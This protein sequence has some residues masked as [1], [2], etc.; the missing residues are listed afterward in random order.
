MMS[1]A[2]KTWRVTISDKSTRKPLMGWETSKKPTRKQIAE[3][4]DWY[5]FPE[6]KYEYDFA[7]IE[8]DDKDS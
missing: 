2:K 6:D 3:D 7:E 8:E 1:K 4:R 5:H